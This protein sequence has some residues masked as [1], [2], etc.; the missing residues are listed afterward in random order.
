[1]KAKSKVVRNPLIT[2]LDDNLPRWISMI[3]EIVY[4]YPD[5]GTIDLSLPEHQRFFGDH[6]VGDP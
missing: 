2:S 1:V 5:I 3:E 6:F 4:S